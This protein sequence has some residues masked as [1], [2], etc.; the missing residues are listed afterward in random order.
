MP[1]RGYN[2]RIW[3]RDSTTEYLVEVFWKKK[4]S[5]HLGLLLGTNGEKLVYNMCL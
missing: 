4:F 2:R 1:T 5:K 3:C